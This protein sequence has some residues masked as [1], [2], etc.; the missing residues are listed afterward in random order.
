MKRR[1]FLIGLGATVVPV[2]AH[3]DDGFHLNIRKILD[4]DAPS[5]TAIAD[6]ERRLH[7]LL[8]WASDN[9]I[10]RNWMVYRGP[11]GRAN[12]VETILLGPVTSKAIWIRRGYD[13]E[14]AARQRA[15]GLWLDKQ[16]FIPAFRE[17]RC[18]N[19]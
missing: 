3:T 5:Y 9:G 15:C 14:I 18:V 2:A 13:S 4:E 12:A 16:Q 1:S 11:D 6:N 7:D 10:I 8:C 17:N 19:V